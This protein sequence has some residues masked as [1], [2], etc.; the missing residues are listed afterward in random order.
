MQK[1]PE[2]TK[3]LDFLIC[4]MYLMSNVFMS[5]AVTDA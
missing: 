4:T 1:L 5:K 3:Q 2:R